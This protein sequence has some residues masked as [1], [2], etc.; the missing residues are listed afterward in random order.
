MSRSAAVVIGFLLCHAG[1]PLKHAALLVRLRRPSAYPN[2]GF[3][4]TLMRFEA[5]LHARKALR[6]CGVPALLLSGAA[7]TVPIVGASAG[8]ATAASPAAAAASA[9][10]AAAAGASHETG[11]ACGVG[12][13]AN[14]ASAATCDALFPAHALWLHRA[15]LAVPLPPEEGISD[16]ECY[17]AA[18]KD[19]TAVSSDTSI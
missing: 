18:A 1:L 6:C 17:A 5:A 15:L 19:V 14:S 4:R 13:C 11:A 16:A 7:V 8:G 2:A 10:I 3:W 9:A 12:S